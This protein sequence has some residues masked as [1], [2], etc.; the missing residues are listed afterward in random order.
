MTMLLRFLPYGLVV[1]ALAFVIWWID[2]NAADRTRQQIETARLHVETVLRSDLRQ[3]EQRLAGTIGQIGA[4]YVADRQVIETN[5]TIIQPTVTR[6]I[7]REPRLS[8]PDA[9][10]T[11]GLFASINR[12]R[13]AL[14]PCSPRPDGGIS[15][16]MPSASP[17]DGQD[18]WRAE[19]EGH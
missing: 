19:P 4:G 7:V 11:G 3:S 18:D 12:A 13:A 15:C 2:D 8:D 14:G 17:A 16:P 10:L 6:E 5:R 9:G 1:A